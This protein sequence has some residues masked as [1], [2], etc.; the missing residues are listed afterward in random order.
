MKR[1]TVRKNS[2]SNRK[3]VELR[4]SDISCTHTHTYSWSLIFITRYRHFNKYGGVN[5]FIWAQ[6]PLP[7][8]LVTWC[9]GVIVFVGAW[10]YLLFLFR[11]LLPICLVFCV[12]SVHLVWLS[13]SCVFCTQCR[14]FL[15]IVISW[16]PFGFL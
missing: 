9:G 11:S 15:W 10:I 1:K 14:Q 16:L 2:K 13:S 6:A 4:N 12:V 5:L 8:L 7:S 3:I